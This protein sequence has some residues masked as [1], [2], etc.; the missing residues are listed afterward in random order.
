[1]QSLEVPMSELQI[2]LLVIGVFVV[3]AVFG[4][5]GWQQRQYRR[6]FGAAFR[7]QGEDAL[8]RGA[9]EEPPVNILGEAALGQA[10]T[11]EPAQAVA[12]VE[13]R[14]WP[15]ECDLLD[16]ATDY[17]AVLTFSGP[18]NAQALAPLWQQRFD[19]R[20]NVCVCGLNAATGAWEKVIA[21]SPSSYSAF[22]LALQLA[23]R[24][25]AASEARLGDFRDL[26]RDI[27]AQQQAGAELPDATAAAA[28]AVELDAFCAEADQMVGLN[29][30]PGGERAFSGSEIASVAAQHGLTLQA[31]GAFHLQDARGFTVF[32]LSNYDNAPFQHQSLNQTQVNGL[33]LL[34][35]VPR[36]EQPARRFDEMAVLAR[37]LA[38]GLHA[39][40]V[41][42]HRVALGE[43]GIARIREQVAAIESRMLAY[44]IIPGSP[45]ARRL[46]S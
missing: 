3:L 28:R 11:A 34:L 8:I 30:L 25:G 13:R 6:R 37:Q 19:F 4:Y 43:P 38:M 29:I 23:D 14:R 7:Q 20:K 39:A 17:V 9:A 35:D 24:S 10:L 27:A 16:A 21:E 32:S 36:V 26:A 18:A 46:F 15:R 1:M 31:D 33:T 2:S 5:N 22:K 44:P 12:R 40:V 45:Q 41:D 42:D